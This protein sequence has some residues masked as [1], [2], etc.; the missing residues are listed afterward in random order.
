[1]KTYKPYTKS[2]R[3]RISINYREYITTQEPHKALTKGIKRDVGRNN[4]G[5]LTVRHKGGGH[6]RVQ[7]LVDFVYSDKMNIPARVETVEYDPNSTVDFFLLLF[8]ETVSEDISLLLK[9]WQLVQTIVSEEAALVSIGNRLPIWL[10]SLWVHSCY[11]VEINLVVAQ[12]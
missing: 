6:K 2:Q 4:H 11:N 7:R 5:R 8:T 9:V 12:N 1:M 10:K 3:N